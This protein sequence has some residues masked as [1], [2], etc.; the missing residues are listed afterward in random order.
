[1][2]PNRRNFLSLAIGG[3]LLSVTALPVIAA[4]GGELVT[5]VP[6]TAPDSLQRVKAV[7]EV[8][9]QLKLNP[10]GQKVTT[11]PIKVIANYEY[12]EKTLALPSVGKAEATPARV[13][14]HYSQ[15]EADITIALSKMKNVLRD[16]VRLVAVQGSTESLTFYSPLGPLVRDELELLKVPGESLVWNRLLPTQAVKPGDQWKLTDATLAILLNIDVITA[17]DVQAKLLKVEDGLAQMEL[18]GT[19]TGA[20][21]GVGTEFELKAKYNFHLEQG[22]ITW[23]AL[24]FKEK[25]AI[26]HAEPGYEITAR[27]RISAA[28]LSSSGYLLEKNLQGIKLELDP[29]ALLLSHESTEGGFRLLHD[30]RWQVMA[31]HRDA[32]ILRMID[33]GDLIAQCNLSRLRNLPDGKQLALDAFQREVIS[34]LGKNFSQV[35]DTDQSTSESGLRQLRVVAAGAVQE[36]PVQWTYYH[37]TDDAGRNAAIV[38]TMDAQLV[39]R[40]AEL[41]RGMASS[42]FLKSRP[43]DDEPAAT[44]EA[45]K[46]ANSTEPTAT[47]P[48]TTSQK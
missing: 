27:A 24:G 25:R 41:D 44:A 16:D 36:V 10:D 47:K 7:V 29:G 14:R 8:E 22:Q 42:L 32:T 35:V 3:T 26:G 11:K 23:L 34:T 17:Q 6:K 21:G 43:I 39:E 46:P 33:N 45:E 40:F 48:A 38:F 15:A 31:D 2:L 37:L 19:A 18:Q 30:R 12:D 20:I 28:P 5:L 4:A 1:M 13:V 9:G